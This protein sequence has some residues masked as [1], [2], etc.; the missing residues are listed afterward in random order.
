MRIFACHPVL[1]ARA[2]RGAPRRLRTVGAAADRRIAQPSDRRAAQHA[3]AAQLAER[4]TATRRH[5]RLH[6]FGEAG[7]LT[8]AD[9]AE[10]W[11]A[12]GIVVYAPDQRGFGA[13]PSRRRW[14]GEDLLVADAVALSRE[15]RARHPDL[16]LT[17]VGHSMG[18]GVALAAAAEGLDADALG[19]RRTR[20]RRGP[21]R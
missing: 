11:S 3:G 4:R 18:G 16:P 21:R 14:P 13:N 2:R 19:A 10:A 1:R 12:R 8:F 9:A 5:P 17:V 7:E 20:H 6:G 15:I